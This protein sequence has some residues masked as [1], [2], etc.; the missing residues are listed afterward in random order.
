MLAGSP[1]EQPYPS[2]RTQARP[3]GNCGQGCIPEVSLECVL[4]LTLGLWGQET[5][6]FCN[7]EGSW[8]T[9][10]GRFFLEWYSQALVAHA[11]RLLSCATSIFR[12]V[13]PPRGTVPESVSWSSSLASQVGRTAPFEHRN[14]GSAER[15]SC[16]RGAATVCA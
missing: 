4:Q 14:Q 16:N 15:V 6:F 8:D 12:S 2:D 13:T 5:G 1:P 11:E 3:V 9:P 7:W 10:Y